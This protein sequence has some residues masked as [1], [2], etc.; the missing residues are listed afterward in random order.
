MMIPCGEDGY[1]DEFA[2]KYC[3]AYLA[4]RDSFKDQKWQNGV[5]TCLQQTMLSKLLASPGA[6]CSQIKNWG[7]A[8]HLGCYMRPIPGSPEINF[9]H[10]P[11]SDIVKIGWT[12]KREVFTMEVMKQFGN[13]VIECLGQYKQD[14]MEDAGIFIRK[15][16]KEL[17]WT[18]GL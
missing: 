9:C 5:R 11:A 10:L 4:E 8:S 3:E 12:A 2:S 18:W 7:F 14:V 16:M 13:M 6:S 1:V 17:G 15:T